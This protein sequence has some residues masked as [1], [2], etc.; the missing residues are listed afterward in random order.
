VWAFAALHHELAAL[1]APD[2]LLAAARA[3]MADE[4]RH[5]RVMRAFAAAAGAPAAAPPP[6]TATPARS[7]FELARENAVEGCV[8]ETFAALVA[9]HQARSAP[10][11]ALRAAMT[12]IAADEI[13]HGELAWRIHAWAS[14]VL[15][16]S[17]VAALE[18]AMRE[19]GRQLAPSL[20]DEGLSVA[21]RA[22]LGLPARDRSVALAEAVR[23]QLWC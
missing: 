5:A 23:R 12:A 21:A 7:L 13:A 11:A 6:K 4:A 19:A 16:P 9:M 17:D 8:H 22:E 20:A 2:E 3:A 14:A 15:A 18:E 1:G 10:D